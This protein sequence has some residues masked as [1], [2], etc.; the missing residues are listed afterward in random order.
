[1]NNRSRILKDILWL[2]TFAGATGALLRLWFGLG[3]TT[4]LSDAFP[5]GLWKIL[6]MVG[7]VALSTSGFTVGLLVYVLGLER[8]RPFVKPA[9]LI[10]FLGY[11]C[12]CLALMFDIG[13]PHR[14]WHP[15]VMWNINSFLFEVFWC[16]L[17]YFTV[18]AIELAP[19]FLEKLR[20]EKAVA[21]LHRVATG[22]VIVGISLSSL[23]HSSLGSLFLVTPQRLHALWYSPW[24]PLLFI[25]SAMGAGMMVV[26]L[27]KVLWSYRYDPAAILGPSTTAH[28]P[29]IKVVNGSIEGGYR[30]VP[31]GPEMPRIT[32]LATIAACILGCFL[33]LKALDFA[34]HGGWHALALTSWE[35]WL[36]A[37][38]VVLL[39]VLPVALMIIPGT[40]RSPIG[41]GC[42]AASAALG[43]AMNRLNVGVFGYFADAGATY[44]PSL[45]EW[46][47]C[48]GVI[49]A[50]GLALF[51][52]A[53]RF[54]IFGPI[55]PASRP[56]AGLFRLSFGSLRQLWNTAL[57]DGLHRVTLIAVFFIPVAFVAMYPPYYD[58]DPESQVRPAAGVNAER[59][60]LLIDGNRD[61]VATT[62]AHVEHQQRLG[63]SASCVKCHHVSFPKDRSTA[64]SRC[65]RAMNAWT[66]IFDHQ[67]HTKFVAEK[68]KLGGMCPI[69]K[70]CTVCHGA[71]GPKTAANGKN[72]MSCHREDMFL[73]GSPPDSS[74]LSRA[75]AFREAMHGTCID[76]HTKQA[77]A[78]G[79]PRLAECQTCHESLRAAPTSDVTVAAF[80]Q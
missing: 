63:D 65:H 15:I 13:L 1:M 6:N 29:L 31:R 62:F 56:E 16:V 14:F 22:V 43:L 80:S 67:Q 26:V 47:V 49:A 9:I 20:A 7:G 18:T 40:R 37:A 75:H 74:N 25:V 66:M 71:I 3:A 54:P 57:T 19:V 38:E 69:N 41:I 64:C 32:G 60:V 34:L 11:G 30:Q 53:E 36:L 68:E 72:C 33:I 12:S 2:F 51:F 44:F 17:L 50:A 76:C 21:T 48:L 52:V 79:K 42:A 77:A 35:T 78:V 70:S 8:F 45:V 39:A 27:I 59:T 23:H 55:P 10:A 28:A 61:G 5:W 4:N 73:L 58:N 24:L 46:A